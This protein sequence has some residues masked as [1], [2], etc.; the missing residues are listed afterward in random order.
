MRSTRALEGLPCGDVRERDAGG[1]VRREVLG[2]EEVAAPDLFRRDVEL[3]AHRVEDRFAHPGLDRPRAAVRDVARLVGV[4]DGRVE[5]V[6]L[7]PVRVGEQHRDERGEERRGEREHGV[8]AGVEQHAHAQPA[9]PPVGVDRGIDF[10]RLF[11]CVTRDHQVLAARLDPLDRATED[12]RGGGE[13]DVVARDL[14]L[15][16]EATADVAGADVHVGERDPEQLGERHLE[17]VRSL[18]AHLVLELATAGVVGGDRAAGLHRRVRDAVLHVSPRDHAV[19]GVEHRVDIAPRHDVLG[20]DVRVELVPER[21]AGGVG[22]VLHRD[23]GRERLVVHVD[24]L[25]RV[26]GDRRCLGDDDRDRVADVAHLVRGQ[27]PER[28]DLEVRRADQHHRA[29]HGRHHVGARDHRD[30]AGQRARVDRVDTRDAR[31]RVGAAHEHRVGHARLAVGGREGARAAQEALVFPSFDALTRE[32]A[33]HHTPQSVV[34]R[35]RRRARKVAAV[36]EELRAV[37][38]RRRVAREEQHELGDLVGL[39][40][41]PHR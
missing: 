11:T 40:D 27:W 24:E 34:G 19:G 9:H 5:R 3:A 21:R 35:H 2:G 14:A 1:G 20:G 6:R 7:D 33:C 15:R 30:D 10:E 32:P 41:P 25:G 12:L 18:V 26:G 17:W 38:V 4:D 36:D 28:R 22:R 31:V 29:G 39:T 16:P 37:A 8:R 13:R 23:D